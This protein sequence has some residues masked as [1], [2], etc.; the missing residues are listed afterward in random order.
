[1]N[2]SDSPKRGGLLAGLVDGW[3]EARGERRSTAKWNNWRTA[4]FAFPFMLGGMFLLER[5]PMLTG[6]LLWL[7]IAVLFVGGVVCFL[8]LLRALVRFLIR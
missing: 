4:L 1:M 8:F 5:M 7:A 3:R 6:F 2:D